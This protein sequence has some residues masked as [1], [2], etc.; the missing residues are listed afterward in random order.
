M[1][2]FLVPGLKPGTGG[3]SADPEQGMA[4]TSPLPTTR[5]AVP[6]GPSTG[7]WVNYAEEG[8]SSGAT[9]FVMRGIQPVSYSKA[10]DQVMIRPLP[11]DPVIIGV[12]MLDDNPV[13]PKIAPLPASG[14]GYLDRTE[15]QE[16]EF[17][18]HPEPLSGGIFREGDSVQSAYRFERRSAV[19][20]SGPI[21]I[22]G[23][24]QPAEKSYT[25]APF[26]FDLEVSP[27]NFSEVPGN[28][29]PETEGQTYLPPFELEA[30]E[31]IENRY[32]VKLMDRVHE[33][34]QRAKNADAHLG[35]GDLQS[36]ASELKMALQVLPDADA[37]AD[38][39]GQLEER[40]Q[41]VNASL[42]QR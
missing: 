22:Q 36:A 7:P 11:Q 13:E 8:P 33:A 20:G 35:K 26:G 1:G 9:G 29:S 3:S 27:P 41:E 32:L 15:Y 5:G 39:R 38:M 10:S 14:L 18:K 24:A 16:P 28:S 23:K 34:F 42:R 40:L 25:V 30:T 31:S 6:S 4:A 2:L 12:H 37:T 17:V 19:G 21:I